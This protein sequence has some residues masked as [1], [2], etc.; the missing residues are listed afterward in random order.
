MGDFIRAAKKNVFVI[1]TAA[2]PLLLSGCGVWPLQAADDI[3]GDTYENADQYAVGDFTYAAA[4]VDAVEINWRAGSVEL[5]E[6]DETT[7]SVAESGKDLDADTQMHYLLD[8]RTLR[9][10]FCRSG[11]NVHVKGADKAL[12]VEL[13]KDIDLVVYNTAADIYAETLDQRSVFLSSFSGKLDC[14]AL[15]ADSINLSSSSGSISADRVTGDSLGVE[16]TSGK[17]EV[18]NTVLSGA[19]EITSVSG[20]VTVGELNAGT[21]AVT[22]TSGDVDV[23]AVPCC[24]GIGITTTSG[25]L[26]LALPEN[27]GKVT[28]VTT[29]GDLK[30]DEPFE[31]AGDFLMFGDGESEINAVSVSG[32]LELKKAS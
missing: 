26:S 29:S 18:G 28:F 25:K 1:L 3:K 13:P 17:I 8:G 12:T 4:D 2:L 14:G 15:A 27:G 10:Q 23:G 22:T 32:D 11:A 5:T 7:L 19:F 6:S 31:N 9:I 21:L 30:T 20:K 24:P 16:S